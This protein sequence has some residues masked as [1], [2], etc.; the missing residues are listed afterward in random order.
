VPQPATAEPYGDRYLL[1]YNTVIRSHV[2]KR[3]NPCRRRP[4]PPP[5]PTAITS[6]P[7]F[8]SQV[9]LLTYVTWR[10]AHCQATH[11]PDH[12]RFTQP[13]CGATVSLVG[14][15][16]IRRLGR[17]AC[18]MTVVVHFLYI[19]SGS[20]IFEKLNNNNSSSTNNNNSN[21]NNNSNNNNNSQLSLNL[22]LG[23]RFWTSSVPKKP[24][25]G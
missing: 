8:F 2:Y 1:P 11:A 25:M 7:R 13:P 20:Y 6:S 10:Y 9:I 21:S 18:D 4:L 5:L 16:V 17:T 15:R 3:T 22:A 12:W 14:R 23:A 24:R 19:S